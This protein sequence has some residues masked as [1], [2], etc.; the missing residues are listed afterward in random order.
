M[1]NVALIREKNLGM[2]PNR[3]RMLGRS[4]RRGEGNY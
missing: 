1:K 4:K 2:K 3:K